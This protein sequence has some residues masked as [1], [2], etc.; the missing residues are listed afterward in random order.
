[1][2]TPS[3]C[4]QQLVGELEMSVQWLEEK[5]DEKKE[6]I[7]E[8]KGFNNTLRKKACDEKLTASFA[9]QEVRRRQMK[10]AKTEGENDLLTN[11]AE[12]FST[13]KD[14]MVKPL[15]GQLTSSLRVCIRNV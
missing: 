4:S 15:V 10:L 14:V 9:L 1:M 13:I 2:Q 11:T 5:R 8:S 7:N 6:K 12:E 3:S